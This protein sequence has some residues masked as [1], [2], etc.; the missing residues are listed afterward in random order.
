MATLSIAPPTASLYE[1]SIYPNDS[2]SQFSDGASQLSVEESVALLNYLVGGLLQRAYAAGAAVGA[3][4]GLNAALSIL[5]DNNSVMSQAPTGNSSIQA[6]S[7]ESAAPA[8]MAP[9]S[10]LSAEALQR[11]NMNLMEGTP[12]NEAAS[13]AEHELEMLRD[14]EE[15]ADKVEQ[16]A[17]AGAAATVSSRIVFA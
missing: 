15:Q 16:Q 2:A 12:A 7:A 9:S 1:R 10:G 8:S 6:P 4:A 3:T 11:Q 14:A 5:T 13:A 17:Q